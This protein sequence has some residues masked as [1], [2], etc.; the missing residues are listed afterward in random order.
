MLGLHRKQAG[1]QSIAHAQT[2]RA[3]SFD[4]DSRA[5]ERQGLRS[6]VGVIYFGQ[7]K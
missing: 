1:V 3:L 5:L 6:S 4:T 7:L 2:I